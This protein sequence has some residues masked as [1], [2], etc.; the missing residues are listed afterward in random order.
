METETCTIC[1]SIIEGDTCQDENE[2]II[3]EECL[4]QRQAHRMGLIKE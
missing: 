4:I 2:N 1:G 3:C